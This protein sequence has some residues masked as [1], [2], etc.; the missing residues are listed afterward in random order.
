M[1]YRI[2]NH[3][4]AAWS[5]VVLTVSASENIPSCNL[6]NICRVCMFSPF[7]W[8]N[9]LCRI[10]YIY[11]WKAPQSLALL[12]KENLSEI[13]FSEDYVLIFFFLSFFWNFNRT[14]WIENILFILLYHNKACLWKIAWKIKLVAGSWK[15][16]DGD[17][18]SIRG[19]PRL[20]ESSQINLKFKF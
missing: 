20:S 11:I 6:R 5:V 19:G 16:A 8:I 3:F 10:D 14:M 13:C 7:W 12:F 18:P 1:L 17:L 9:S 2:L 4:Q 15:E